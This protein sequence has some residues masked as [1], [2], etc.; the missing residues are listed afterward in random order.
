VLSQGLCHDRKVKEAYLNW[1]DQFD[2]NLQYDQRIT[3]VSK[4]LVTPSPNPMLGS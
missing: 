3:M 1:R 4:N 2:L